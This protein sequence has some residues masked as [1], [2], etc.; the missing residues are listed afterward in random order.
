MEATSPG[1]WR[2]AGK[3]HSTRPDVYKDLIGRRKSRK[4]FWTLVCTIMWRLI[5]CFLPWFSVSTLF[6]INPLMLN[7]YASCV[8]RLGVSN[9]LL[10]PEEFPEN[11]RLHWESSEPACQTPIQRVH[12]HRLQIFPL[13]Y[14]PAETFQEHWEIQRRALSKSE[15][16]TLSICSHILMCVSLVKISENTLHNPELHCIFFRRIHT[17]T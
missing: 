13:P 17:G 15:W 7:I 16:A 4:R 1:S 11:T 6:C 12:K 2:D 3:A 5:C 8:C 14:N 10:L 9:F